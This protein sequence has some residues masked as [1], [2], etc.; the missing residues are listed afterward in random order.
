VLAYNKSKDK[1]TWFKN[2]LDST[3]VATDVVTGGGRYLSVDYDGRTT[4][5]AFFDAGTG[6]LKVRPGPALS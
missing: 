2:A 4:D 1:V 6:K 3:P 5:F